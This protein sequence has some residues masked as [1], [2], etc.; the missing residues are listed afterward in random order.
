MPTTMAHTPASLGPE[1]TSAGGGGTAGARRPE[2][3]DGA[4]TGV[5]G[6]GGAKGG[7]PRELVGS[8]PPGA[9]AGGRSGLLGTPAGPGG[10]AAGPGAPPAPCQ[11]TG[12]WPVTKRDR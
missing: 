7:A 4:M 3:D 12:P 8:S 6:A 11:P 2:K 1:A 10:A 5:S 9:I